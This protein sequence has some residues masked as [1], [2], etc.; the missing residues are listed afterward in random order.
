M[1]LCCL[2]FAVGSAVG[3]LSETG[4]S[5]GLGAEGMVDVV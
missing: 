3:V 4:A 1:V 2:C 5:R